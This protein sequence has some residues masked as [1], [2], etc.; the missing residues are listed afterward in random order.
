MVCQ[1]D[2]LVFDLAI[3]DLGQFE[4]LYPVR[5]FGNDTLGLNHSLNTHSTTVV[6]PESQLR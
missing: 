2:T 5:N 3:N 4:Y 6:L 1:S